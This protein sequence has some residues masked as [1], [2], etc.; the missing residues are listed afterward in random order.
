MA[1][2]VD[3]V[4]QNLIDPLGQ[5]KNDPLKRLLFGFFL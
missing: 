3:P 4:W 2:G 5:N 1:S